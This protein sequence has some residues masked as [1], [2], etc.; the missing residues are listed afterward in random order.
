LVTKSYIHDDL[1]LNVPEIKSDLKEKFDR[2]T[3]PEESDSHLQEE[4]ELGSSS[5][6]N[7]SDLFLNSRLVAQ[8]VLAKR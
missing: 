3:A 6:V 7:M 4:P 1:A 5:A 8:S 2:C